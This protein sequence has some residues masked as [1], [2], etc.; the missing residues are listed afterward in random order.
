MAYAACPNDYRMHPLFQSAYPA[1][2]HFAP[3]TCFP[4]ARRQQ[5]SQ[6]QMASATIR[7][8]C[9][10]LWKNHAWMAC[11]SVC[12]SMILPSFLLHAALLSSCLCCLCSMFRFSVRES[13]FLRKLSLG[14]DSNNI[15]YCTLGYLLVIKPLP[16]LLFAALLDDLPLLNIPGFNP[17]SCRFGR[18]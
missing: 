7:V 17:Q 16:H 10:R 3:K 14:V 8:L 1:G 6:Q 12:C 5:C 13:L 4:C 9:S 15:S 2:V 11:L 18:I